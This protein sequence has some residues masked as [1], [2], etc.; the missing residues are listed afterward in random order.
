MGFN[1]W[2]F[3]HCDAIFN[4]TTIKRVAGARSSHWTA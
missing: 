4:E 3:T 1:T 2:N